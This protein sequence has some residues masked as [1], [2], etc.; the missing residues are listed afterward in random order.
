MP[1][2]AAGIL[3][4]V[5]GWWSQ[6]E[7]ILRGRTGQGKDFVSWTYSKDTDLPIC[8]LINHSNSVW[9]RL[10]YPER[11]GWVNQEVKLLRV[12]QHVGGGFQIQ[13]EVCSASR[14]VLKLLWHPSFTSHEEWTW[15]VRVGWPLF[16]SFFYFFFL[17]WLCCPTFDLSWPPFHHVQGS[18]T[19]CLLRFFLAL[20]SFEMLGKPQG[21]IRENK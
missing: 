11:A 19:R 4:L 21:G 5:Q 1:E 6:N 13:T 8:Y 20:R 7:K 14:A 2:T 18:W 10:C 17:F 15:G 12:T 3:L 16:S 9:G